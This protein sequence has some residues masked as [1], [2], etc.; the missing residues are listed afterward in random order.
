MGGGPLKRILAVSGALLAVLLA[1]ELV[2]WFLPV[3]YVAPPSDQVPA[4][5]LAGL[6]YRG[7]LLSVVILALPLTVSRRTVT[8]VGALVGALVFAPHLP[9]PFGS[10]GMPGDLTVVA[11]YI[12][13]GAGTVLVWAL[14]ATAGWFAGAR[15]SRP[16]RSG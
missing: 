6:L 15:I 8:G 16:E 11:I 2:L 1:G 5:P 14:A 9:R 3:L 10:A 4:F 12:A 7:L 13:W